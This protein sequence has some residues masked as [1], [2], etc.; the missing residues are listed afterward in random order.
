[1]VLLE[2]M[3]A[4]CPIV[5][6]SV[7]GTPMVIS[8]GINGSLVPPRHPALLA[9]AIISLLSDK[10]LRKQY[11]DHGRDIFNKHFSASIMT[12]KYESLY[13]RRSEP[14]CN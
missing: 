11:I 12:K 9:S 4:G 1:M 6:T 10:M 8:H 3:A 5:A 7:G 14:Q 2:A 13:L